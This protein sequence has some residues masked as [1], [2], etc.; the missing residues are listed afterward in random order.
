MGFFKGPGFSKGVL[1]SFFRG[2]IFLLGAGFGVSEDV[3]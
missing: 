2:T 1:A 3:N